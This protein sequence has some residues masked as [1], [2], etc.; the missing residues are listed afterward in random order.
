MG[1]HVQVARSLR[2]WFEATDL[3][4]WDC[5]YLLVGVAARLAIAAGW[6]PRQF[7]DV[8]ETA[9]SDA[10]RDLLREPCDRCRTA[11]CMCR[12]GE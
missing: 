9:A 1:K 12:L 3:P 10:A 8:V 4:V 11:P 2:R 5:I 7:K 6:S